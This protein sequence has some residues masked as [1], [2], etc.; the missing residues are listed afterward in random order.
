MVADANNV[1]KSLFLR[2]RL[3][4]AV[5]SIAALVYRDRPDVLTPAD[6][7]QCHGDKNELGS[8]PD[9]HD[10]FPPDRRLKTRSYHVC[11]VTKVLPISLADGTSI[12]SRIARP[13]RADILGPIPQSMIR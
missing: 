10:G 5:I 13:R 11:A 1:R 12:P 4:D 9:Q 6:K 2:G 8:T 3:D 7:T